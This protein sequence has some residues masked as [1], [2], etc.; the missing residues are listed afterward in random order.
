VEAVTPKL[1]LRPL[2]VT[3]LANALP[4]TLLLGFGLWAGLGEGGSWVFGAV[5]A[6][7]GVA[8][9]LRGHRLSVTVTDRA[10][11]IR[12]FVMKQT[13]PRESVAGYTDW[14]A[15]VWR[16]GLGL[17]HSRMVAFRT[18]THA[19]PSIRDHNAECLATLKRTAPPT[20][21]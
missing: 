16:S 8:L 12:G 20:E 18:N 14:P 9:A 17:Q 13:I 6:V 1:E 11:E 21:A 7:L 5:V 4:G 19:L 15:V 2:P 10:V 3:R